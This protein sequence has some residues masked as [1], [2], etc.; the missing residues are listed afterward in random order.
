MKSNKRFLHVLTIGIFIF[1][2]NYVFPARAQC[3]S[4]IVDNFTIRRIDL[5]DSMYIIYAQRGDSIYKIYSRQK[6]ESPQGG[7][8]IRV[9]S[10]YRL[11]LNS[12][13]T[14]GILRSWAHFAR[15]IQGRCIKMIIMPDYCVFNAFYANNIYGKR[16]Y[17]KC[18]KDDEYKYK[19]RKRMK[20][21][22]IKLPKDINKIR[23]GNAANPKR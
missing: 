10:T 18:L 17:E 7:E 3:K 13:F 9:G 6:N 19:Y 15:C 22:K 12:L 16:V 1:F 2:L 20:E 11:C 21:P 4:D 5:Y 8:I 23:P 14:K